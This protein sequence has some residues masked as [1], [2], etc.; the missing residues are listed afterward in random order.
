M[1]MGMYKLALMKLNVMTYTKYSI[2][3]AVD[4]K[5]YCKLEKS[6]KNKAM[7]R[8]LPG[9]ES[10]GRVIKAPDSQSEMGDSPKNNLETYRL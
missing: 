4:Y 7:F 8:G 6:G 1:P 5:K 9:L 10:N 3:W 2:K